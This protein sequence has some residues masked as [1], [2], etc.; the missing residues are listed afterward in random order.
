MDQ[1]TTIRAANA[2]DV[3][4]L[5]VLSKRTIRTCY[6]SFLGDEPVEGYIASG[7]VEKYDEDNLSRCFVI[8]DAGGISG[9]GAYKGAAVDL[10]LIDAERHRQGLGRRVLDHLESLL[11]ADSAELTLESF[12]HNDQANTF[13]RARGWTQIDAYD[14]KETGIP[15]ILLRKRKAN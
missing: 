4:D 7:A 15:M 8:E 12:A 11:F 13:Y 2:A 9:V 5:L 6:K 1:S 3:E 10:M 14:D